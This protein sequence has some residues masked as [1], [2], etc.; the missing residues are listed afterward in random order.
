VI[1]FK[2]VLS[3]FGQGRA[4]APKGS[5][6]ISA[7]DQVQVAA[8]PAP[9]LKQDILDGFAVEDV[10]SQLPSDLD[11]KFAELFM[12]LGPP[13]PVGRL[14]LSGRGIPRQRAEAA[15]ACKKIEREVTG[16]AAERCIIRYKYSPSSRSKCI[17]DIGIVLNWCVFA[18]V[19]D[20]LDL[21]ETH[22]LKWLREVY[23]RLG[24]P[25]G[26]TSV[27]GAFMVLREEL[28]TRLEPEHF[29]LLEPYVSH[30]VTVLGQKSAK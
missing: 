17:R 15:E 29:T 9:V 18:M 5:D 24:L 22:F 12:R 19:I 26:T 21:L 11:P 23:A 4:S 7:A 1:L 16:A 28:A 10:V 8:S 3:I 20:D 2:K 30:V 6:A 13:A 25:G 14:N 27:V